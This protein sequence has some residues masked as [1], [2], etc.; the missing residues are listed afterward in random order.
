MKISL[1][2]S[3]NVLKVSREENHLLKEEMAKVNLRLNELAEANQTLTL[4][5]EA[6]ENNSIKLERQL[7][8]LNLLQANHRD[9]NRQDTLMSGIKVILQ[10]G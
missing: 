5:L 7:L 8:D 4:K 1:E 3:E 6:A 9:S 2:T 10:F